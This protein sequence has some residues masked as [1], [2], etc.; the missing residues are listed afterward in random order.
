MIAGADK[1]RRRGYRDKKTVT[2]SG[3]SRVFLIFGRGEVRAFEIRVLYFQNR[4]PIPEKQRSYECNFVSERSTGLRGA[5][6]YLTLLG[7]EME[8]DNGGL[9]DIDLSPVD[10]SINEK[11]K[12]PRDF[13]PEA[14][15]QRTRA[16]WKPKIEVGEVR[17]VYV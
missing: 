14:D 8:D 7:E 12:V 9:F 6:R 17:Y 16:E 4:L 2:K 10:E 5:S 13:Q 11:E 15:F 3:G 1:A